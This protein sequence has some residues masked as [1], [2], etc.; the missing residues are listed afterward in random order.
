M[1]LH[2]SEKFLRF[3]RDPFH[4]SLKFFHALSSAGVFEK[5]R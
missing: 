5:S 1:V 2:T 3:C 4:M